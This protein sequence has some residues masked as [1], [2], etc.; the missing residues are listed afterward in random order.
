MTHWTES[1]QA[2]IDGRGSDLLLSAA[3]GSG[4][5]AVLVER[6]IRRILDPKDPADISHMLV[7]TFTKAAAAEMRTR[8]GTALAAELEIHPDPH[9]EQQITLLGSAQIST[10]HAFCQSVIRQYFYLLDLDPQ[11]RTADENEL[12]LLRQ[13][14]L[15]DVLLAY[16]EEKDPDFLLCA[17]M[18]S[19][20]HEDSPLRAVTAELYD[21]SR[22]MPF[23]EEWLRHLA[24]PYQMQPAESEEK[25]FWFRSFM[26]NMQEQAA[27]WETS[28][29]EFFR[30]IEN[31]AA[32]QP[33]AETLSE[34]YSLISL[35]A[36][37][38][39]W[40]EWQS[41]LNRA[42]F[43]RLK[44]VSKKNAV[45]LLQM[46]NDK[47]F[48][49]DRRSS[50]KDG[51]KEMRDRFFSR[52]LSVWADEMRKTGRIA[53]VL[54]SLTL[55]FHTAYQQAKKEN[56][57]MDFG[58]M[59][60]FALS[61][62]LDPSSSPGC[63][64]PSQAAKELQ[65]RYEEVLI[66]EYQDTN[67]VQD[68][69]TSLVSRGNNRF[70]V[71]DVKQSI[72]RFR[73]A[74]PT[75]FL[76]KY[77]S[78]K[79]GGA[80]G[81]RIDLSRNFRSTGQVL[82]AANAVFRQ[83]MQ[84]DASELNYGEDEELRPGRTGEHPPKDWIGG[85]T[86]IELIDLS[87]T[88]EQSQEDAADM[89]N[90]D[91]EARLTAMRI[92][93]MVSDQ[94]KIRRKDGSYTPV[95]YSDIAIL[96]RA[97]SNKA[98]RFTDVFRQEDI[99]LA[100][101]VQDDFL[102]SPEVQY[103]WALLKILDNPR[104]DLPM[105]AVLRSPFADL[106]EKDLARLRLADPDCLW[107]ALCHLPAALSPQG[108]DSCRTFLAQYA[109]WRKLA[110]KDSVSALLRTIFADTGLTART[111]G[112]PEGSW[113]QMNLRAFYE[114]ALS[115]DEGP[116]SGLYRFL[117]FLSGLSAEDR[118]L[119]AVS[120]SGT[121]ENAVQLLSVHKSKGLEFPIVFLCDTA[122]RFNK[123][124]TASACIPH[125]KMGIGLSYYNEV[126]RCR[127]S[128][129]YRESV[130]ITQ[131][132][133]DLAEEE[134]L[135]YV[136]MTRACDKLIIVG[137]TN[138]NAA[139]TAAGWLSGLSDLGSSPLPAHDIM[140]ASCWLDWIM[141][142]AAR[143]PSMASL[144]ELAGITD[145]NLSLPDGHFRLHVT[146]AGELTGSP[147][148]Q[149]GSRISN[150]SPEENIPDISALASVPV[151]D[152]M[153]RQLRWTYPYPGA[154]AAPA[155]LT[156]TAAVRLAAEAAEEEPT[157]SPS[158][159]LAEDMPETGRPLPP[160]LSE[161]PAFIAGEQKAGMTGTSYGT[162]MHR[163]ME[164][165]DWNHIGSRKDLE[166][167][168]KALCE[169]DALT[170][171]EY[172]RL[173]HTYRGRSPIDD[174]ETFR[175]SPLGE[176]I[177][178]ASRIRHE[179]PFSIL[180]PANDFYPSCEPGETVFLQGVMDCIFEEN[181]SLVIVDYKTDRAENGQV[182]ADHYRT[183]L[184]VYARSAEAILKK[185]VKGAYLWSFHL[186]KEIPVKI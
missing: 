183:Q 42:A 54:S 87:D 103:L 94:V 41:L 77:E 17:D 31:D 148:P 165:T 146:A 162:L 130:R 15:E 122:K 170:E 126:N 91:Y 121:A 57:L 14:V 178:A 142:A 177:R 25:P 160:D 118:K 39:E 117:T 73:L 161:I 28:Y 92:R 166:Q 154:V 6:I 72:Y 88:G 12:Y 156:A 56:A 55:D 124:S 98:T 30:L 185:H 48:I 112:L 144:W 100:S 147:L 84:K 149:E 43:G 89:E 99:P 151:P 23:P 129:L 93:Q 140:G 70:M 68:L 105:T 20:H 1:Q 116:M 169:A 80:V 127:W 155:K 3:A 113:K 50:V 16:Y 44:P 86:D 61:I 2:A 123:Q 157:S 133:E 134:R 60:H 110:R 172:D 38:G 51:L 76:D 36:K 75:I 78:F 108:A 96:M 132:K 53:S 10:I 47:E 64:V 74:D 106:K 22:A 71:G 136:A 139:D 150:F 167:H 174:L 182:L 141:T 29:R 34:E 163:I 9:I 175:S 79:N 62:L 179:L 173:F 171:E 102:S 176:R 18:F 59:E 101:A 7:L 115:F 119:S 46:Q 69:I 107:D 143:C 49:L 13:E 81:R 83:I 35:L 125:K 184:A 120:P 104:Q 152:W 52:P 180:L 97:V 135:L 181:G 32:L 40:D 5:T 138:K 145:A 128:T 158:A 37:S 131:E 8:I 137:R 63:P 168:V 4:K 67:R 24:D 45:D 114:A 159:V 90:I 111:G 65:Q 164:M 85:P 153:D 58:D 109:K 26:T 95:R 21:F 19:S 11:V 186:G 66:D 27:A 33:Y 82:D